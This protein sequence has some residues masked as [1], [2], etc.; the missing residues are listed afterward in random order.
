MEEEVFKENQEIIVS[1]PPLWK[2]A[3]TYGIYYAILSILISIIMYAT[4][5]MMSKA[6]ST[7]SM[8]IMVVAIVLIQLHYRKS[9]GGFV[10]YGQS[11]V[12]ALLSM[13]FAAIPIAIFTFILYKFIDPSLI[14]QLRLVAEERLVEQGNLSQEQIDTALSFSSK[15]QTPV[16]IALSQFINLPLTG[17]IIG[18]ISSIFI[19]KESPD[20]IF[21]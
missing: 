15:F 4:G 9:T 14:E 13:V 1:R 5:S 16:T 2:Q 10:T 18:A 8:V 21:E 17:L 12:I 11:L 3:L 6:V 7:V 20:K 19:K